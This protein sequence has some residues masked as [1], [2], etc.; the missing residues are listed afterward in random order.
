MPPIAR[1][2]ADV[3]ACCSA[4]PTS[5]VRSGN[6]W[7]KVSSPTGCIIA[8][9]IATTSSRRSPMPTMASE[10]WSVQILPLG[11]VAHGRV[12]ALALAGDRV[13]DHGRGEALG[14]GERLL[15]GRAV[16]AVDGA[17]V[18]QA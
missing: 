15:H 11:F 4:M 1:P 3:A 12:V 17:D 7:A 13:D 6:F 8:A 16:V 5:K 14:V 2:A 18:L 9:V 10:K